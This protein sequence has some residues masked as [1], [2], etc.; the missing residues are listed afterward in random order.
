MSDHLPKVSECQNC[1]SPTS[2]NYCAACGQDSRDHVVSLRLLLRDFASD[3][4]TYDSRFFRSFVPLLFKPGALTLEYTR[5]RRVRYIPPLRLYVFVSLLFFFVISVQVNSGLRETGF[6]DGDAGAPADSTEVADILTVADA[7]PD[8]LA[9]VRGRAGWVADRL[10]EASEADTTDAGEPRVIRR[11]GPH[12]TLSGEDAGPDEIRAFLAGAQSLVPKAIF[13]LQPLF[14]GL[15]ALVYRR[16]R[17]RFIEH[18]VLSLHLHAF[19]FLVFTLMMLIPWDVFGLVAMLGMTVYVFMALKRVYGQGW[20]K[21]GV[22]FVLLVGAYNTVVTTAVILVLAS[23][24]GLLELTQE[25]PT[26]AQWLLH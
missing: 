26:L 6:L 23:S 14:A 15:L 17:R 5:G 25:H 18:L 10:A 7:F 2:S 3:V 9:E 13:L 22:K 21:T 16:N 8:S 11:G 12:F 19:V 4:F 20:W 24:A 1:G